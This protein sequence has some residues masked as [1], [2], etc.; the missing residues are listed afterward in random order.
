MQARITTHL[1]SHLTRGRRVAPERATCA[2][3]TTRT[4]R[5]PG[6]CALIAYLSSGRINRH[7]ITSGEH[8]FRKWVLALVLCRT[9]VR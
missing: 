9:H 3:L 4:R 8:V 7:A 1:F 5:S 2:S 6:Q